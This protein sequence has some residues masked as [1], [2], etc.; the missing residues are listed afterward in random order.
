LI[1]KDENLDLDDLM[2]EMQEPIN[3]VDNDNLK[4]SS[5]HHFKL[6]RR[7]VVEVY[8]FTGRQSCH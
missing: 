3:L 1:G 4:K 7:D 8:K 5:M 6:N 2:E